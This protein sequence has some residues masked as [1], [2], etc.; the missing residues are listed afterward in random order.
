MSRDGFGVD[1]GKIRRVVIVDGHGMFYAQQKLG[2]FFDPRRL[3]EMAGAGPGVELDGA[4]WYLGLKDPTD[5]RPFRD[6][7]TSLGFTVRSKPLR[8]FGAD[9]EHRQFARANLD[10]EICLDLMLVAH[11]LDEVWLLS[12]SRDLERVVETLRA[13][14][15]RIT[16]LNTDGMVPRELRNAVDVFLD[17]A[18]HRQQLEKAEATQP[19]VFHR[20]NESSMRL[21]PL[22]RELVRRP[23][24]RQES[25]PLEVVIAPP[26]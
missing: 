18:G 9:P 8:E 4:Y 11:R 24:E 13:R 21:E 22:S 6:A 3:L 26:L 14:G 23:Q 15:V 5:Q 19:P 20:A 7:L 10:V 16:L 2:W 25:S 1:Q 12:G 17:L